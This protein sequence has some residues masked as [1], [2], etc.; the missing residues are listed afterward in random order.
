[1]SD[2]RETAHYGVTCDTGFESNE[3]VSVT[4]NLGA[5]N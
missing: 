3:V 4:C 5:T 2:V 1:M